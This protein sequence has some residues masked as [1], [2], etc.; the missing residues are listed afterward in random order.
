MAR[1]AA[2][3]GVGP[4]ATNCFSS[5]RRELC[6]CSILLNG[7]HDFF[8]SQPYWWSTP[9]GEP[10]PISQVISSVVNQ[11]GWDTVLID[12][13]LSRLATLTAGSEILLNIVLILVFLTLGIGLLLAGNHQIQTFLIASIVV[14]LIIWYATEAFGMIFTGMSTDFNS[15]LLL[16]VIALACIPKKS[17]VATKEPVSR[18]VA[19]QI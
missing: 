6:F 4:D 16:V 7:R 18:Q 9:A 5:N 19:E 12:P 14:S 2:S 10:G 1:A 11:G 8:W 15:G 13:V 17:V 3:S